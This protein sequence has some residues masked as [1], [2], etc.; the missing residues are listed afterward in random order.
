MDLFPLALRP[1]LSSG[2]IRTPGATASWPS[3][4][5]TLSVAECVQ[6]ADDRARPAR[7]RA[8]RRAADL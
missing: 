3:R 4:V 7:V 5:C 6:I 2:A 8:L 1:R